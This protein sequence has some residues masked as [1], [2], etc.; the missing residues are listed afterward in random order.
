MRRLAWCLVLLLIAAAAAYGWILVAPLPLPQPAYAFTVKPGASLRSVAR[1]LAASGVLPADWILVGWAR[2]TGKDRT[3]KAGNYELATGMTLAR[4]LDKLTQG[5]VTQTAFTIIEGWSFRELRSALRKDPGIAPAV[6]DL[7][8][9]ELMQKIGATESVPEGM[10]FPDT[11]YFATGAT[12]ASILVRA[13]R[14]MQQRLAAA[15]AVR[16]PELPL[17]TP[18]EALTLASIVEKETGRPADRPLIA[19]VFIN[20]LRQGMRLQTDPTVIYGMGEQFA[21]NLKRRDLD[22]D[23]TFN[24]YTRDGLPPTPIALPSQASIDAVLHPPAS[25]FLYFVARGDGSSE[26]STSLADHNRAV[27]KYQRNGR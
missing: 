4:L 10:F 19:A 20:R 6:A 27:A 1:E 8:D 24:T 21:G 3:I 16:A 17:A 7:P 15:W 11:Y 13:Y 25:P 18:Y 22:A 9:A 26:F 5:D 2:I 14:T 12:D 23:H